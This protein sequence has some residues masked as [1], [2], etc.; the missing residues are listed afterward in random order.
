MA[1]ASVPRVLMETSK[2][3]AAPGTLQSDR[4]RLETTDEQ[5]AN[6]GVPI[7]AFA[8]RRGDA[9]CEV[10]G[11]AAKKRMSRGALGH[12]MLTMRRSS[13]ASENASARQTISSDVRLRQRE[14]SRVFASWA[15][16]S[17]TMNKA[18]RI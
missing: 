7:P 3:R 18:G 10:R 16:S 5:S 8:S 6:A 15:R 14:T 13:A 2:S 11:P 12:Q 1:D 4:R 9:L 17:L